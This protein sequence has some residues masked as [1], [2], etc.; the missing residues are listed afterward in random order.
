MA[1]PRAYESS[2]IRRRRRHVVSLPEHD[3][4]IDAMPA[5]LREE[6]ARTWERRAHEELKVAAAF[7]VLCREM[8]E[9]CA[10]PAVLG[11]VSR[12]VNDEVRHA[13]VCRALASKYRGAE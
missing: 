3:P 12:G 4:V 1:T 10:D 7:S 13:E 8:L 6:V 2:L 9:T 5:A 11:I